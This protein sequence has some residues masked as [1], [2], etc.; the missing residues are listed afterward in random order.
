MTRSFS[1]LTAIFISCS[2]LSSVVKAEELRAPFNTAPVTAPKKAKS[3][4]CP[5]VP[6]PIVSL[7]P[8]SSYD[9]NDPSRSRYN[10]E[11][12]E[13][14]L[15]AVAPLREYNAGIVKIANHYRSGKYE[16]E[17]V[18]ECLQDWLGDWAEENALSDLGTDTARLHMGQTIAS[19][20]FAFM[21][22]M[23]DP[24][25]DTDI[26]EEIASWLAD[27]TTSMIA[28]VNARSGKI[29]SSNNIRYW[30]GLGAAAAGVALNNRTLFDWGIESARIGIRQ[31]A[32]DGTL[33]TELSRASRAWHYHFFGG[34]PLFAAAELAAAN[35][36]DLYAENNGALHRL[37]KLLIQTANDPGF[38]EK[39]T[40]KSQVKEDGAM[41]AENVIAWLYLYNRRFPSPQAE[42]LLRHYPSLGS[43][44]LGGDVRLLYSGNQN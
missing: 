19:V 22:A 21:Q 44:P 16:N 35:G 39:R 15:K 14:Y 32:M 38:F 29:T 25:F 28:F 9:Q 36:I 20:A 43:S 26:K 4:D 23:N 37:A 24:D 1:S 31:I 18:V 5:D 17:E 11:A 8:E 3:Y 40:G 27:R 13:N 7:A 42:A 30:N 33:P 10:A 12:R 41:P 6:D 2:L 34:T